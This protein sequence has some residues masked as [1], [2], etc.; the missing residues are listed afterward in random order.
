MVAFKLFALSPFSENNIWSIILIGYSALHLAI[1]I[2]VIF[3]A[4]VWA[5]VFENSISTLAAIVGRL[6][7]CGLTTTAIFILIQAVVFRDEQKQILER[8]DDINNI[9]KNKLFINI[10]NERLAKKYRVKL[11]G[12][13]A[14]LVSVTIFNF[15]ALE[16][17]DQKLSYLFHCL[18]PI[19]II[20]ARCLQNIFLVD[21]IDEHL[22]YF[23]LKLEEII[24]NKLDKLNA[25]L[26]VM[27]YQSNDFRHVKRPVY[28]EINI[29]KDV[30]GKIWD[31]TNLINDAFGW[32]LLAIATQ[33]FI[34]F[35]CNG[36]WLFL[37]MEDLVSDI[38]AI[39]ELR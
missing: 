8:F 38:T 15:I 31:I 21:L 33:N 17:F 16:Y 4:F 32:S 27:K 36:Y 3:S 12:M 29:L 26:F 34:E 18:P 10:N 35:T 19:L 2:V 39:S 24:E 25:I 7:I 23:N 11:L 14:V 9:M 6:V 1:S 28:D 37:A 20:R 13:V 30:Y 22:V 5:Q